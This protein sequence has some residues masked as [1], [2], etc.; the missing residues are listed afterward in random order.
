MRPNTLLTTL[1][2]GCSLLIVGGWPIIAWV[3]ALMV[4]RAG[5]WL[6]TATRID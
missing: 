2:L 3:A 5:R 6:Y 1:V 4:R